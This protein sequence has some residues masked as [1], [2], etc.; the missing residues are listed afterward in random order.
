MAAEAGSRREIAHA[1]VNLALHVTG[2]RAD[3]FHLLDSLVVF[4]G[5]GDVVSLGG[6]E[7]LTIAGPFAAGLDAGP[8]NLVLRAARLFGAPG[9]G[10]HLEKNLPVAA[11]LGGGS[12]DAAATLRLLARVLGCPVP[13]Q[14][15]VELGADVPVCLQ[16][17]P[18]RMSGIG[19]KV[20]PVLGVPEFWLVLVNP[21]LGVKTASIYGTL[22]T[23]ENAPMDWPDGWGGFAGFARFLAAQRND[24]QE[25]A[26]Q[27]APVI[28]E[29]LVALAAQQG[30]ALARMS[31]SGATCFGVFERQ[32][33][34]EQ[35]AGRISGARP[36]WWVKAA[37][38][39]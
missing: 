31:G 7:H 1:K 3:G 13:V 6:T 19:E 17:G 8:G 32:V 38:R 15:A 36:R 12:A 10:V 21:R 9:I 22:K 14:R 2:R 11:G 16:P 18:Q 35:A 23:P 27:I 5:F 34:A 39:L 26:L 29:V 28:G 25:P 30:C 4:A 33:D 24:L 37:A 20:E